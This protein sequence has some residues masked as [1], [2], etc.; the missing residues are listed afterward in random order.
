[1]GANIAGANAIGDGRVGQVGAIDRL[2]HNQKGKEKHHELN[3]E[4]G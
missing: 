4:N 1:M 2:L 3:C